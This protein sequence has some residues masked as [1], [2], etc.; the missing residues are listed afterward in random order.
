MLKNGWMKFCGTLALL[1]GMWI[2]VQ[3]ADRLAIAE[4]V[5]KGGIPPADVEAVWGMLEASVGG[6]YELISRGALKQ[7]LTEIGL[8][9]SS[10]LTNLNSTQKAKLGEL[11]TVKY[12]LVPTV[13]RLGSRINLTLVLLDASTGEID[14]TKRGSESFRN[15]DELSDQLKDMLEQMGLGMPAKKSGRTA[16]LDPIVRV[17]PAPG[18]LG[19]DFNVRLEAALLEGGVRLQNL[20]N[21][22]NILR[23]NNIGKLDEAE[24]ALFVRVGELLRVDQLVQPEIT[25]FSCTFTKEYIKASKNTVVRCL[26]NIDGNVRILSA[27]TGELTGSIPFRLKVDFD[28][29]D[30]ADT[31]DWTPEDYGKYL[32]ERIVPDIAKKVLP[33]LK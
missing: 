30:P 23:R 22:Q 10:G 12:L 19:T 24:P 25:R 32:I 31:E 11:K 13:S 8:T 6:G 15:L 29:L 2:G 7:M 4:P 9:D 20:K 1:A 17:V 3:A 27:R 21:V 26:G 33:K 28:D 16:L 5:A 14:A 18:Y